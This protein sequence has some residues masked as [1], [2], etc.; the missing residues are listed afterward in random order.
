MNLEKDG[1]TKGLGR[2][3]VNI[4][5]DPNKPF[6]KSI[7]EEDGFYSYF[8]LTPGKY[9]AMVDTN[10]LKKLRMTSEPGSIS[11]E[12]KGGIDGDIVEGLDFLLRVKPADTTALPEK[13]IAVAVTQKQQ[14]ARKDTTYMIVHEVTQVLQESTE[15]SF[16]VQLGAFKKKANADAMRRKL[17]KVLG[18]P[19]EIVVADGFYKVRIPQMKDRE[20]VDATVNILGRNGVT[21]LWVISMKAKQQQWVLT[22]RQDTITNI[23]EFLPDTAAADLTPYMSI[24]VGAFR[25]QANALAL[26]DKFAALTN[27]KVVVV[28]EDGLYK[29]RI[30][31]FS[32]YEEM[33]KLIPSLGADVWKMPIQLPAGAPVEERRLEFRKD[34][35][36][37]EKPVVLPDTARK[38]IPVIL[39]DTTQLVIPVDTARVEVEIAVK[40]DT[41]VVEPDRE[42]DV[43][44]E[45]QDVNLT[46]PTISLHAAVFNKESQAQRA[47][48]KIQSKLNLP[49]VIVQ[50]WDY[51][52]VVIP[53]FFTREETYK[54]YPE[55]A[56]LGFTEVYIIEKK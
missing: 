40:V 28:R 10:Q 20:E 36:G 29:V 52:H 19:L 33:E 32:S 13:P 56:G 21:E 41:A 12:I 39:P 50:Q 53:G 44:I 23:K 45:D 38:E 1:E 48:S 8:G 26:R 22:E 27:K 9:I 46:E 49:A 37:G 30:T 6:G 43:P 11:F 55:L 35:A 42:R 16:A 15:D 7:S 34:T 54:Y 5:K 24:Q 47:V 4:L 25:R 51:Y 3:I 14:G 2:I 18:R 31:G 17:E